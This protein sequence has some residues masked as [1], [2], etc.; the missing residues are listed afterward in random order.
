M[1][2][3]VTKVFHFSAS[4]ASGTRILG[5]NYVLEI[6]L[7]AV[8]PSEESAFEKKVRE[9]LIAQ[10]ESR[11]LGLDVDFLRGIEITDGNLL[12]IFWRRVKEAAPGIELQSMTLQRDAMTKTALIP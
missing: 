11:D 7:T 5:K 10:L 2:V 1:K 6:T 9:H 12:E 4:H 3:S 8:S